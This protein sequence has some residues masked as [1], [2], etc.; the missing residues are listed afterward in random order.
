MEACWTLPAGLVAFSPV[1]MKG[2]SRSAFDV[3]SRCI[4]TACTCEI[5][6]S[7]YCE[8][9]PVTHASAGSASALFREEGRQEREEE[10]NLF[11]D[12]VAQ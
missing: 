10:E 3:A 4:C 2:R 5:D 8:K 7:M 12:K 11:L 1:L 6:G 9:A